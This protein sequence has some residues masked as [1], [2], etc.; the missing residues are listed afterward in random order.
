MQFRIL[1]MWWEKK[2]KRPASNDTKRGTGI[3]KITEGGMKREKE[4]RRKRERWRRGRESSMFRSEG[5]VEVFNLKSKR[6]REEE[7]EREREGVDGKRRVSVHLNSLVTSE[8]EGKKMR[9][10]E[11]WGREKR[12]ERERERVEG[13]RAR[14][15]F[16]RKEKKSELDVFGKEPKTHS[17]HLLSLSVSLSF[18]S[19]LSF[20]KRKFLSHTLSTSVPCLSFPLNPFP[21]PGNLNYLFYEGKGTSFVNLILM[22]LSFRSEWERE[23]RDRGVSSLSYRTF[24]LFL[25]VFQSFS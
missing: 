12:W 10:R 4:R 13:E 1:K 5:R 20:P 3:W 17:M 16:V 18:F 24:L 14:G 6:E 21:P 11:S 9:E 7:S 23:K 8:S 22:E 2:E 15:R 25:P 19:S